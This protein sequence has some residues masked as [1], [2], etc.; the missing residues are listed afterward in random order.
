MRHLSRPARRLAIAAIVLVG[1]DLV[2]PGV[3]RRLETSRYEDLS[4]DFRFENS[5]LF[6][7]GPL[8]EYLRDNPVGHQPRVTFLGNSVTYGY[9]LTA[10]EAVPGQYQRL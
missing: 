3:L 10:A 6:G 2:E 1:V 5:D 7:V 9:G 4:T 8:V